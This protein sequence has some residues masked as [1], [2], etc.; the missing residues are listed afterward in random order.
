MSSIQGLCWGKLNVCPELLP[1]FYLNSKDCLDIKPSH[2][3]TCES[4]EFTETE[5][6]NWGIVSSFNDSSHLEDI[7]G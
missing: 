6:N 3:E 2:L 7:G 1:F 4:Q 5:N